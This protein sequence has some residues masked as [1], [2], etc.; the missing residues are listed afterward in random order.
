MSSLKKSLG[1]LFP[2]MRISLALALLTS[3]ILLSAEMLGLTPNEDKFL[4]EARSKI[5]ESLAIQFSV[6]VPDQDIKKIHKLIRY[7]VKRNPDILSAGI[8][9]ESGQLIFQSNNHVELWQGYNDKLSTSSHVIVPILQNNR[10]W[11]N[12]ELRFEKLKGESFI[13]FFDTAIFKMGAF[14]LLVGFFVYLAFMLRTLR[15]LDPSSIIP[16]RVNAAFDALSE[17]VIII[18]EQEQFSSLTKRLLKKL[19]AHLKR[20]SALKLLN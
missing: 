12:V 9:L 10:L 17:S 11:G 15:Q 19:D 1:I 16:E 13:G 20:Y 3:C 7:I 14:I 2:A 4:L 18:D 5:S 6:L 8:R